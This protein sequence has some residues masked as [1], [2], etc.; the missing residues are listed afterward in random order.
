M[1]SVGLCILLPS[2]TIVEQCIVLERNLIVDAKMSL[3]DED[4]NI[5]LALI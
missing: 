2:N 3:P 4:A 5:F 1:S